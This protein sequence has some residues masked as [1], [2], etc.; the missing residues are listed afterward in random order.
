MSRGGTLTSDSPKGKNIK[1]HENLSNTNATNDLAKRFMF[2]R[3]D[4]LNEFF[5][6]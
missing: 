2:W 4:T 6:E 3:R 5:F 1:M